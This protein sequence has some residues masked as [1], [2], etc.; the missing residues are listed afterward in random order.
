MVPKEA[1]GKEL[2][3]TRERPIISEVSASNLTK[4]S[5]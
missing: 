3:N 5:D 2:K 1:P 4:E